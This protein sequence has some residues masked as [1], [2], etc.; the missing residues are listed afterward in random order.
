MKK[1]IKTAFSTRQYMLSK[2]FEIYYYDDTAFKPVDAHT[3]DYYEFYFFLEGDVSIDIEGARFKLN[4]GDVVLIPPGKSHHPI[5][6]SMEHHYRRFVFW[7][8]Q[9]YCNELMVLSADYGYLMQHAAI[10]QKYIYHFKPLIF[11]EF[12][13][14]IIHLIEELNSNRFGKSACV[15][16]LVNDLVFSLNR[17]I[18]EMDNPNV[19]L[20]NH[21][22]YQNLLTYIDTHINDDISL[23]NL[24]KEFYVSK[25]HISHVFKD[26]IGMSIHQYII[27][28]R[29]SL[30]ADG[31]TAG[32]EI[33][34]LYQQCGFADY[35]SFYRAFKKEYG[36][37]PSE[38]KETAPRGI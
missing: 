33:T 2:D 16:L 7:I 37:S 35:S 21:S 4:P 23:E 3:H 22:L 25:F 24:A 31:I 6:S 29:L 18:Y 34:T 26:N 38:Y 27:K 12:Q 17:T 32:Q 36:M 14:K 20:E 1:N 9:D 30:C 15:S 19:E 10:N 5:V 13:S 8:S 28:R 11:N